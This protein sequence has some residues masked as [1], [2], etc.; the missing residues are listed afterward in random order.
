M[1]GSV[2]VGF[3]Q[4]MPVT[5]AVNRVTVG[6]LGQAASCSA[7]TRTQLFV[8]EHVGDPDLGGSLDSSVQVAYSP[9]YVALPASPG[10]VSYDIPATGRGYSFLVVAN[11]SAND[12]K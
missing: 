12:C 7:P 2:T 10:R 4:R 11:Y 3:I 6:D 9:S 8:R 1:F 5:K